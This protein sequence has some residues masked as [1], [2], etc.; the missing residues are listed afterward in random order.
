MQRAALH[1]VHGSDVWHTQQAAQLDRNAL[2]DRLVELKCEALAPAE[3]IAS[4]CCRDPER[5]RL[6]IGL[7]A[8][9][10]RLRT[11]PLP[12]LFAPGAVMAAVREIGIQ[13]ATPRG[14]SRTHMD[15]IR[16]GK[17]ELGRETAYFLNLTLG[18]Q[19]S[20][21]V[22]VDAFGLP[23]MGLWQVPEQFECLLQRLALGLGDKLRRTVTIGTW[24][25]WTDLVMAA[26]MR[27]LSPGSQHATFDIRNH[28]SGCVS[29]LL[30][31]YNVTQVHNGWYG[32]KE[33]WKPLGL[34]SQWDK[35]YPA[36]WPQPVLDFCFID[37]GHTYHLANRDFRTMRTA[38]R[39]V[40]FHD[41]VNRGVGFEN[42]PQLWLDLTNDTHPSYAREFASANC[43]Q[44]PV[45]S[46]QM[47]GIGVLIRK[48][49]RPPHGALAYRPSLAEA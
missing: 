25:G 39:S 14:K 32:G 31:H 21:G 26:Y 5:A 7:L 9:L 38:C 48:A 45:L 10:D 8:V 40:A 35:S 13:P 20:T 17:Q 22:R 1:T 33:S 49:A 30:E 43:T 11:Q 3:K 23:A 46:G 19:R 28:V 24:S 4:K 29:S 16:S 2:P 18:H 12:D 15:S 27:R 47:M 44:Q 42:Q 41:I 37:G 36:Q 34:L 6:H